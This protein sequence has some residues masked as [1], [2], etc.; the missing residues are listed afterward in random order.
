VGLVRAPP[1]AVGWHRVRAARQPAALGAGPWGAGRG[2]R[3]AHLV[4]AIDGVLRRF[5]GTARVW[6]T[7]RL[8]TVVVPGTGDVQPSFAPVA[9]H[10]GVTVQPCPSR[11]ANRKGSVESAVRFVCGRWWRTMT[12]TTI[13]EAQGSLDRF[14][15]TVGDA[16]PRPWP[17]GGVA[18]RT[19][20]GALAD[21]EP[22]LALPA[23]P[24]P[25]TVEVGRPVDTD[26]T[27]AFRGNRYSVPPGLIGSQLVLGHRLG[28]ATL[29]VYSAAGSLLATHRLAPASAGQLVRTPSTARP[30]KAS[31]SAPSRPRGR[32]SARATIRPARPRWPRRPGCWGQRDVRSP[33]TLAATPSWSAAWWAT[34]A[35]PPALGRRTRRAGGRHP[36]SEASIYQ[37]LRGHLAAL[38]MT[39][40]AEALPQALER[41]AAD[42]TGHT[43]FLERLLAVEV[44]AA[45]A[46][47]QASLARF[48]CLPAPWRIADFDFD[49]QPSVD[50]K[51]LAEL[52]TLRFVADKGNVLLI[53]PPGVGKTMLAVALGHAAVEA[54]M[55]TYYTTAAELAARC[56]KAALEGRWSTTMRF[57]A[58]PRLLIIDELGYLP[59]PAEGAAALFQVIT[60]RYGKGSIVLTTNLGVGSWGRIFDDPTVAA[61]MLDRLLHRSVVVNIDGESY[62]MRT[63]RARAESLRAAAKQP[64]VTPTT[65][66]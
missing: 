32:A 9:K 18:G 17:D 40:A 53:G 14:L 37:R 44:A 56:H 65:T 57:Y 23:A 43:A 47:R 31:C 3:P 4:E 36:M 66:R 30:L 33:S 10:Y 7:D 63:H 38:R 16:R 6:R 29:E 19:T 45:Q 52:A 20:V 22:L 58:G 8:A 41:A 61:A 2:D 24:Y 55:R 26:A 34:P 11:R 60:Q 50:R 54:G 35:S 21:A 62:R 15:A 27:V 46:R 42:G 51:L 5:G 39:A 1:G 25:A 49:A 13:A 48:A 59:M 28:T 12:A 64:E